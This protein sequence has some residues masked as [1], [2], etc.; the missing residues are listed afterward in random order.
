MDDVK[1]ALIEACQ[2]DFPL[3]ERPFRAIGRHLG[4]SEAVVLDALSALVETG[5][6]SRVG[7]VFEPGAAGASTLAAMAVPAERLEAVA[8]RVSARPEVNHNYERGHRLN[9][10]FVVTAESRARVEAVLAS[11]SAEADLPVLDLPMLEPYHL[12]LGFRLWPEASYRLLPPR[13]PSVPRPIDA[14]ADRAIVGAVQTG[15]PLVSAP[16]AELACRA[17]VGEAEVLERLDG[18]LASGAVRRFGLVVR[19]HELGF[20]A[21]AMVVWDVPDAAVGALAAAVVA[22]GHPSLCYRRAR[23]PE[24]P[25]NL[26]CMLHG[27][28]PDALSARIEDLTARSGLAGLPREVLVSRR[29][30]KQRG[31]L[32][33][34]EV[35]YGHAG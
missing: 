10:W 28:D 5:V 20:T 3:E 32:Y 27:R 1:R 25:Y 4:L 12:D 33:V 30:F 23:R 35:A 22:T 26:Y 16:F 13:R 18:W 17:G 29:R 2:R 6:V 11:L 14:A 7:P 31:A 15:L 21:N 24:W 8:E 9:L 34:P 19:H